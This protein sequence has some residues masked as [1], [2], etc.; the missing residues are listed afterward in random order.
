MQLLRNAQ[1]PRNSNTKTT[2]I[3]TPNNDGYAQNVMPRVRTEHRMSR[4]VYA[5]VWDILIKTTAL[6]S[7]SR[8]SKSLIR[9]RKLPKFAQ[10]QVSLAC[11]QR[12]TNGAFLMI[13]HYQC[14]PSQNITSRYIF[15]T[16]LWILLRAIRGLRPLVQVPTLFVVTSILIYLGAGS[17]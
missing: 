4:Y 17:R 15:F 3:M 7:F 2:F 13:S 6:Q 11:F 5:R 16:V 12:P 10:I 9:T 1:M 14:T 8:S